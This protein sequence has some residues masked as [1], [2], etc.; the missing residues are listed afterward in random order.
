PAAAPDP[1]THPPAAPGRRCY[2]GRVLEPSP[3]RPSRARGARPLARLA[4]L[5]TSAVLALGLSVP[6][7]LALRAAGPFPYPAET[8]KLRMIPGSVTRIPLRSLVEDGLE[9]QV[10]LDSARLALPADL[11]DAIGSRM[12]LG[13]DSRSVENEGAGTW[14]PLGQEPVLTPP[15]AGDPPTRPIPPAVAAPPRHPTP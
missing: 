2:A 5:I 4:A 10:D 12:V 15:V 9:D 7:A 14:T 3:R 13:E 1:L 8:T 6:A 11:S